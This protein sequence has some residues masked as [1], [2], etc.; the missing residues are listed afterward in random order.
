MIAAFCGSHSTGKSTLLEFFRE[1]VGYVCIDSVTRSSTTK[2][3]RRIDGIS[4][5]N[6]VQLQMCNNILSK[7]LEIK[8]QYEGSNQIVLLDRCPID[9]LAYTKCFVDRGLVSSDTYLNIKVQLEPL[10]H[11]L[12][13]VFYA[14]L[15]FGI[16]DDGIR[17]LDEKLRED[18]DKT[19]LELLLWYQI[20]TVRL[21]GS[22]RQRLEQIHETFKIFYTEKNGLNNN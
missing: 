10:F 22:V 20:R 15:E 19:I 7:N 14:P 17:S 3:E 2:A 11:N 1:R 6:K 13:V 4:D 9:F 18:V 5:L 12:D 8:K 21:Q 16:V